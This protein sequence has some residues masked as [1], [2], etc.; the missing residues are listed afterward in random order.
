MKRN[1]KLRKQMSGRAG[2]SYLVFQIFNRWGPDHSQAA[3]KSWARAL[4]ESSLT[5]WF[6]LDLL[7]ALGVEPVVAD[8]VEAQLIDQARFHPGAGVAALHPKLAVPL[9]RRQS[10][11]NM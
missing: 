2:E 8:L 4:S 5:S 7:T 3:T 10:K 11:S 1:V 6:G 9:R